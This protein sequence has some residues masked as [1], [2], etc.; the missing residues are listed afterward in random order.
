[1]S[2]RIHVS[3]DGKT[4]GPYT[5]AEVRQKI[6]TGE[7]TEDDF[8]YAEDS[9]SW[10]TL[11]EFS[12]GAESNFDQGSPLPQ[13]LTTTLLQ[14]DATNINFANAQVVS[15]DFKNKTHQ[16]DKAMVDL[17]STSPE[18]VPQNT[19]DEE[20]FVLKWDNRYGPFTYFEML[21]MLQEKSVFEFDFVWTKGM[22]T[23]QRVA[24]VAVFA[25]N[26]I[27]KLQGDDK[28]DKK[29]EIFFRRRHLRTSFNGS[30][31]V[32]DNRKIWK[33]ESFE[34]SEGGAGVVMFNSMA[35]PGQTLYIHFKA[36]DNVPA[37][38]AVCEVVSKQYVKDLK[39]PNAPVRY[40]IK[41]LK[42]SDGAQRSIAGFVETAA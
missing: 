37:F 21:K 2:Q 34:I 35:L 19:A 33:G 27:R 40:G 36:G 38:N 4:F 31:I 13:D 11:N 14:T 28:G 1:M 41:F 30:I 25:S 42:I 17:T 3:K 22:Q 7:L 6:A 5:E 12:V 8:F 26:Y 16:T 10:L 15:V 18:P 9:K 32:H 20:W 24:E 29:D 39:D 23:W